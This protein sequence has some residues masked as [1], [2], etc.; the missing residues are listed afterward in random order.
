LF[1]EATAKSDAARMSSDEG[2]TKQT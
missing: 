2:V 1:L